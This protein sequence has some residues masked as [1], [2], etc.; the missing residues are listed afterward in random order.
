MPCRVDCV[1][2]L[3]EEMKKLGCEAYFLTRIQHL[4]LSGPEY[5]KQDIYHVQGRLWAFIVRP[6]YRKYYQVLFYRSAETR[7]LLLRV[8]IRRGRRGRKVPAKDISIAEQRL[9]A[10][11]RA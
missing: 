1:D 8:C 11:L 6:T 3:Y 10:Y 7:L 4:R 2:A 9:E 5:F